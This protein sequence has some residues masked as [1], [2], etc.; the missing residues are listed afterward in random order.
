MAHATFSRFDRFVF[1][2]PYFQEVLQ[3][4]QLMTRGLDLF[5]DSS[6]GMEVVSNCLGVFDFLFVAEEL[7]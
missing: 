5:N 6:D 2:L 1:F 4:A 3:G 7:C